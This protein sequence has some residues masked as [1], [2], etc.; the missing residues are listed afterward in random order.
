MQSLLTI[1]QDTALVFS[2][3]SY[4]EKEI[5][6]IASNVY[7]AGFLMTLKGTITLIAAVSHQ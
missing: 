5:N 2:G 4:M 1:L 6:K 3:S 7:K